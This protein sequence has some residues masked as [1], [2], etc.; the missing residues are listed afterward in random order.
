MPGISTFVASRNAQHVKIQS[1]STDL[2][3]RQLMLSLVFGGA[4]I[5][6]LSGAIT[7]IEGNNQSDSFALYSLVV[8]VIIP[9]D[10]LLSLFA[11]W[12]V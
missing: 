4:P 9:L 1:T 7:P 2:Q 11:F 8:A 12:L 5:V 10:C 3:A 6:G